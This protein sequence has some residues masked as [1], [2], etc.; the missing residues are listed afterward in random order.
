M[1]RYLGLLLVLTC[2]GW[3]Q[4]PAAAQSTAIPYNAHSKMKSSGP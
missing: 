2:G 1:K 3:L 4:E